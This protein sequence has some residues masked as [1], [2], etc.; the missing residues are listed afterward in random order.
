VSGLALGRRL[1][2]L[3]VVAALLAVAGVTL[4]GREAAKREYTLYFTQVKGLYVGDAVDVLG[5]RVGKVVDIVP[6]PEQV[7]VVI[8]ME[9]NQ[10]VPL[11]V[12]AVLVAPSLVSVRHVA[13][14]PAYDTGPELKDGAEIP[15]SRTAVPVEWDEVKAQLVRLT[16]A[17]GPRGANKDG[18]LTRLLDVSAANLD[19]QGANL[20]ETITLLSEAMTTLSDTGGDLFATVRN[21]Q[22]FI[23]ALEASDDEVYRFNR[24]LATVA[25]ILAQDRGDLAAA[26]DGLDTAFVKVRQLLKDNHGEVVDTVDGLGRA[27]NLLAR[28]RQK[29]A[30]ILQVVPGTI[31]NFYNIY[32]PQAVGLTGAFAVPNLDSPANFICSAVLSLGGTPQQ[33]ESLLQPIAQ[34]LAL[35]FPPL[36]LGS[37]QTDSTGGPGGPPTVPGA[38][39]PV[40]PGLA[41]GATPDLLALLDGLGGGAR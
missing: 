22:V 41:P 11:D 1:V 20:N 23:D 17:L 35:P 33:C 37:P 36:A 28:N 16:A 29:L 6:A 3:G 15:L 10:P 27:S 7:E 26:L 4:A 5:V 40:L 24:S 2:V 34:Y 30:D 39:S 14:A 18:S 9:G 21:L 8:R 38:T 32:D 25:G 19:S 12:K 13:L 31:T